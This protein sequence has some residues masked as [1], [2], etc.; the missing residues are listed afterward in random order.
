MSNTTLQIKNHLTPDEIGKRYRSCGEAVERAHWHALWLMTRNRNPLKA[1]QTAD[2]LGV[3]PDWI[4]K[5]IR[6]FNK[7]GIKGLEDKRQYN[8]NDPVLSD[9]L[10]KKLKSLL[11]KRPPDGG[12]WTGPKVARWMSEKLKR[13]VSSVTGWHYLCGAGF[14]PQVPRPSHA[15]SATPLEKLEFKKNSG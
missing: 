4:R 8:G 15:D 2:V 12:L 13:K 5:L 3:T 10:K 7:E 6:R 11:M 1:S 14:A 9:T